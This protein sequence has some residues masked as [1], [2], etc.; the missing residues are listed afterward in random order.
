MSQKGGGK[1]GLSRNHTITTGKVKFFVLAIVSIVGVCT[2]RNYCYEERKEM[3]VLMV[4]QR[5]R[6]LDALVMMEWMVVIGNLPS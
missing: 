1:R 2:R 5:K 3:A 4:G 6:V